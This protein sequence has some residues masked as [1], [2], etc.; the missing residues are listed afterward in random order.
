MRLLVVLLC[1]VAA[2]AC[3]GGPRAPLQHAVGSPARLASSVLEALAQ[4]DVGRLRV[5]ALSEREFRDHIWHGLPAAR[6][7]RNLPVDYVWGDLKQKSDLALRYTF[8]AHA[9]RRY[10]LERVEFGGETTTYDTYKVHRKTT[11]IV[12]DEEGVRLSLHLYGSTLEKD[13]AFKVFSYIVD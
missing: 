9:G 12:R 11:L 6:P 1:V 5:I 10:A 13:G 2:P 7:E 4:Y 3:A 8:R